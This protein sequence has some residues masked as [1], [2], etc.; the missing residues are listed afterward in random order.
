M[1]CTLEI[2]N[3]R[4]RDSLNTYIFCLKNISCAINDTIIAVGTRIKKNHSLPQGTAYLDE[5]IPTNCLPMD[6]V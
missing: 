3:L 5:N 2:S 1:S 4:K 6:Y